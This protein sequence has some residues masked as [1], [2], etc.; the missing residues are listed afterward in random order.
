[1]KKKG[2]PCGAPGLGTDNTAPVSYA[3]SARAARYNHGLDQPDLFE[4]VDQ[5]YPAWPGSKRS[6]ATSREAGRRIA[7]HAET[8]RKA[9]LAEFCAAYPKGLTAD[10]IAKLLGESVLCVRPRC[11]E[12]RAAGLIE[13]TPDRRRNDSGMTAAVWRATATALENRYAAN[14]QTAA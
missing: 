2:A 7:R 1:M 12:L 11:S 14:A 3:V 8:V 6:S 10:E 9:V 13:Q 5:R 4:V